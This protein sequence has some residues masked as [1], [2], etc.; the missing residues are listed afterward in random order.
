MTTNFVADI[1][2]GKHDD[3]FTI[4]KRAI[5]QREEYL[6]QAVGSSL[7][8]GDTVT[9]KDLRPKYLNGLTAEIVR[10]NRTRA[11]VRF[12][13]TS[14]VKARKYGRGTPTVPFSCLSPG[15]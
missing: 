7:R 5:T 14:K 2:E 13:E 9:L 3:D 12:D 4:I 1:F 6:A 10:V 15:A 11:V 8:P